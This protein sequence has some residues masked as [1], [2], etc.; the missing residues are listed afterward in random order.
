[1]SK[2]DNIPTEEEFAKASAILEAR[3]RG[4]SEVRTRILDKFKHRNKLHEFFIFDSSETTFIAYIFFHSQQQIQKA[5]QDGDVN[6]IIESV[7]SEMKNV[8]RGD[9][10]EINIQ[11]ELDSHE[12]VEKM[13]KG[14]YF[15]RLR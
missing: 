8:G 11:F 12:N 2:K 7:F 13:Y 3:S 5:K 10:S 14:D 9:R 1:M 6:E 15:L 4:L